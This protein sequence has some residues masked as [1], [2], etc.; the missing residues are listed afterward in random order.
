MTSKKVRTIFSFFNTR[1]VYFLVLGFLILGVVSGFV[2]I[3]HEIKKAALIPDSAVIT[4]QISMAVTNYQK[5]KWV[6]L[7]KL[8]DLKKG[9]KYLPLPKGAVNLKLSGLNKNKALALLETPQEKVALS[10][11]ERQTLAGRYSL[12]IAKNVKSQGK[13]TGIIP[14]VLFDIET[15][16]VQVVNNNSPPVQQVDISQF[17]E[18]ETGTT[19]EPKGQKTEEPKVADETKKP[20]DEEP[21]NGNTKEQSA[22]TGGEPKQTSEN[23]DKKPIPPEKSDEAKKEKEQ[24]SQSSGGGQPEKIDQ[25]NKIPA[26]STE[27]KEY[28]LAEYETPAPIMTE[29]KNEEGKRVTISDPVPNSQTPV[30]NVLAHAIIPEIFKVG[31]ENKI[32][33]KWKNENDQEMPFVAYDLNSNGKLDYIEW[34]VP[35]LSKQVFDVIFISKAFLLTPDKD[36][37][38]DIY[39]T[40][41]TKDNNWAAA[42]NGQYVRVTF[43]RKLTNQNDIT[44]Y[45]KSSLGAIIEVYTKN[46]SKLIA[47]FQNINQE[48]Y[49]KVLLPNLK[50]S[51]DTFDLKV[52]GAVEVDFI[53]DAN[54]YWVGTAGGNTND[55]ANWSSTDPT[56]CTGGG[57]S[58]P[59]PSDIAIFDADCDNSATINANLDVVGININTGYTGTI[60]Q[61]TGITVTV[62]TSNYIQADGTFSGGNS[63]IDINGDFTISGGSFTSTSGTMT[64]SGSFTKSGSPTFVANG[65]TVTFDGSTVANSSIDASGVTFNKIVINRTVVSGASPL[66]TI[67]SGTTVPLGDTATLTL[68][69]TGDGGYNLTNN[70]TITLGTGTW[71]VNI[72]GTLTNA[73]TI[74]GNSLSAW[75]M[76]GNFTNSGSGVLNMTGITSFDFDF[77]GAFGGGVTV[78]GSF[79][80]NGTSTFN[81]AA[82]PTFN[83]NGSFT[84]ASGSTFPANATLTLDGTA[85]Y[86]T[87]VDANGYT[88]AT[89][90]TINRTV[91]SGVN[92]TL[93]IASGTT[94][95]LGNGPT[96]TLG[97]TGIGYYGLTNNGTINGGTGTLTFTMEGI[98][99]N[100]GTVS[101]S[102]STVDLVDF[103]QTAGSF[104]TAA[105]PTFNVEGGFQVT[106][107][108]FPANVTLNLDGSNTDFIG[109]NT[110]D[111]SGVTFT[112]ATINRTINQAAGFTLTIASGTTIPLGNTPTVTL[113]NTGAGFYNLSN[114]GTI[115]VGTGI[116]TYTTDVDSTF[117]NTG[118]VRLSGTTDI[119]GLPNA[120]NDSGTWEIRGDG[121]GVQDTFNLED[122]STNDYNNLTINTTDTNDIV[123]LGGGL[124]IDGTLIVTSGIFSLAGNNVS[125]ITGGATATRGNIGGTIRLQGAE[126]LFWT[127]NDTDSGTYEYVT[128]GN[129]KA[130]TGTDYYNLTNSGTAA[131]ST[132]ADLDIAGNLTF[133]A[134]TT[135]TFLASST[136]TISGTI[137]CTGSAGNLITINSSSL[138]T[139]ATLS[140]SSG[141]VSCNYLHLTDSAA[142][143]G[144]TWQPGSNSVNNGG[145]SGW[146]FNAVPSITAGPS[147]QGSSSGS[148]TNSGGNLRFTATATDSDSDNYYLAICKTSSITVV[149]SAAP[150][151]P[152]GNWCISGATTSGSQSSCSYLTSDLDIGTKD[153]YAFLCDNNSSSVCSS[154]LQG[155]GSSGSPFVVVSYSGG[156]GGGSG[157]GSGGSH[158]EC[159]SQ[160]QC[161][162]VSGA[163]QNQCQLNSYADNSFYCT[164]L[165]YICSYLNCGTIDSKCLANTG[166][167]SGGGPVY[168]PEYRKC[169]SQKQCVVVGGIGTDS[170]Q[171]DNDCLIPP[172]FP[173]PPI[174]PKPPSVPLKTTV[175]TPTIPFTPKIPP[176]T[177]TPSVPSTLKPVSPAEPLLPQFPSLPTFIPSTIKEFV[178]ESG[179]KKAIKTVLDKI[180]VDGR[181]INN[182]QTIISGIIDGTIEKIRVATKVIWD[183]LQTLSKTIKFKISQLSLIN[184]LRLV[185]IFIILLFVIITWLERLE[186]RYRREN[187]L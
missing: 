1:I 146:L 87:T 84:V 170:C 117:S 166:C 171:T 157:S 67:V 89:P 167:L 20:K 15:T 48:A 17:I 77:Y 2:F 18:E 128:S 185:V 169:N 161:L 162:S 82:N 71:T 9:Q 27:D 110:V 19:K 86:Q 16:I 28:V 75:D 137:S 130:F 134:G 58:V 149:N 119:S 184:I 74:S 80:N 174:T 97:N 151:C 30:T 29:E 172:V 7:V 132:T 125:D 116:W 38:S 45:A 176:T 180:V 23:E 22:K 81:S 90:V 98:F 76:N 46:S 136:T 111:A 102:F 41:R 118:T 69:N 5:V 39:E 42:A 153:W 182:F 103:V 140:K 64:I 148:P 36:I 121:D 152:G 113:N 34:V 112:L 156:S 31:Q 122:F 115:T 72:R 173:I 99:T 66:L 141:T 179:M 165:R 70:G 144:A 108:T 40:V 26:E 78:P 150:T 178:K 147:D 25:N 79:A 104:T 101:T 51:T 142:T 13:L 12:D 61:N 44:L 92:L 181:V 50:G 109:P 52:S 35:H 47:T 155:S 60:T 186:M 177:T 10:S 56:S 21:K 6:K 94:I 105:S 159:N 187:V 33:I 68:D 143:G 59:G 73:G 88:F 127:T 139:A 124:A 160:Q 37:I 24:I 3:V 100:T 93:T 145:N 43:E 154:S 133:S 158:T 57:A 183:G 62:G 65:G 107:G 123:L 163:G 32:K 91:N 129:I 55:T 95:P 96:V 135:T 53:V 131:Y 126:T 106:G 164:T 11:K 14:R 85:P 54:R 175:P 8:S 63:A 138:G 83:V 114:A 4:K 49:Y 168:T 120:D